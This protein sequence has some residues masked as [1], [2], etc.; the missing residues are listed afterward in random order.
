MKNMKKQNIAV[1][2]VITLA[3]VGIAIYYV[4]SLLTKKSPPAAFHEHA[5][6]A[7]Y[8]DG[9]RY[10]FS[11]TKY[12]PTEKQEVGLK[13]FVHMHDMNGGV[14]HLHEP[15]IILGMFFDSIGMQLNATCLSLDNGTSYCT[16]ANESLKM[17]ANGFQSNAFDQLP[18]H[19]LDRILISYGG[20]SDPAVQSQVDSVP[21]DACIYSEKCAAPPGFVNNESLSCKGGQATVCSAS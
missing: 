1:I 21:S 16:S 18:L 20:H 2:A 13:Q 7:V 14:I 3:V 6:F 11:Q 10:N 9:V 12:I 5:N 17:Y 19:D 15:G 4:P 8:I